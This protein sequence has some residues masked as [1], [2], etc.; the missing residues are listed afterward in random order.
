M[1]TIKKLEKE[2]KE[3]RKKI[4]NGEIEIMGPEFHEIAYNEVTLKHSKQIC[5]MI[6]EDIELQKKSLKKDSTPEN[7]EKNK[8]FMWR[9]HGFQ[10]LLSRITGEKVDLYVN[11]EKEGGNK[12]NGN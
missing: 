2:I 8:P 4:F 9:I 5:E 10:A 3:G 7:F 6:E 1:K 12:K 11:S